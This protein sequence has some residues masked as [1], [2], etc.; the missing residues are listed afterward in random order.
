MRRAYL[1]DTEPAVPGYTRQARRMEKHWIRHF[2]RFRFPYA[3]RF[4]QYDSCGPALHDNRLFAWTLR[5][6]FKEL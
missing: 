6:V 4:F 5:E 2:S 3:I 1:S